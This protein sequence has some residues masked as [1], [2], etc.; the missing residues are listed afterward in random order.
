MEEERGTHITEDLWLNNEKFR[1][2]K[3]ARHRITFQQGGDFWIF[4]LSFF[5]LNVKYT[6]VFAVHYSKIAYLFFCLPQDIHPL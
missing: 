3:S 4:R 1:T 5:F 2:L 6:L